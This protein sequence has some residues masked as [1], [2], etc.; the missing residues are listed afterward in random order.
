MKREKKRLNVWIDED[1]YDSIRKYSED[2]R[3]SKG[4]AVYV[5]CSYGL[6]YLKRIKSRI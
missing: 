6:E 2:A 3:V 5:L 1:L 4:Y